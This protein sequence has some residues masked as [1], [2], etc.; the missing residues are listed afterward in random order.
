[1]LPV[2][3]ELCRARRLG[4]LALHECVLPLEH[5]FIGSNSF[6]VS[7]RKPKVEDPCGSNAF[8]AWEVVCERLDWPQVTSVAT[9]FRHAHHSFPTLWL[10]QISPNRTNFTLWSA[11]ACPASSSRR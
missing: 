2:L 5:H 11:E 3:R 10:A 9:G 8:A 4:S 1:M 6:N 7:M